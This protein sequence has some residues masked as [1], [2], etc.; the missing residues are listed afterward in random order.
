MTRFSAAR[1]VFSISLGAAA[2]AGCGSQ[3]DTVVAED[4]SVEDVAEQVSK[5]DLKPQPGRW[6]SRMQI[7]SIEMP[8]LPSELQGMMKSQ[9]GKVRT[10]TS[11]LTQQEAD[12]ADGGLFKPDDDAGCTYEKFVMGG[13]KINAKMSCDEGGMAR[14]MTM[15]GA[16]SKDAYAMDITAGGTMEGKPVSMAMSVESKR[17]GE[18]DGKEAS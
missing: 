16:Y 2:L 5:A 10:S 12:K 13:G 7:K 1:A 18:C 4:A 14:N 11:C 6:E 17:V 3:Q 8:G 9:L 15:T